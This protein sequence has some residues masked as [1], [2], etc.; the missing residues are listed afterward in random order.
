MAIVWLA[1]GSHGRCAP[2]TALPTESTSLS[3][4]ESNA[5]S[6][7]APDPSKGFRQI[8]TDPKRFSLFL[9]LYFTPG[10]PHRLS[11]KLFVERLFCAQCVHRHRF[12]LVNEKGKNKLNKLLSNSSPLSS[13]SHLYKNNI[14]FSNFSLNLIKI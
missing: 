9:S 4:C 11:C 14:F 1:I 5:L 8:Q 12:R 7:A 3:H 13:S 10:V 6:R 2:C